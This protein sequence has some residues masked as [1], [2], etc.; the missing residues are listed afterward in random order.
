QQHDHLFD[1]IQ[2]SMQWLDMAEKGFANFHITF[3][4]HMSRFLGFYPNL[5]GAMKS[6]CIGTDDEKTPARRSNMHPCAA[7]FR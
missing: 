5:S 7:S 6:V 3:L 4:I 2:D 1:Y